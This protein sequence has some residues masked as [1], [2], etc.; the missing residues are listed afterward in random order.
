M[1]VKIVSRTYTNQFKPSSTTNFFLGNVGDWQK[2]TLLCSFAVEK[3]FSITESL[4]I[5]DPNILTLNDGT[6]WQENGFAVGMSCNLDFYYKDI[7]QTPAPTFFNRVSFTIQSING[8]TLEAS[9]L[10]NVP[11]GTAIS[12]W[13]YQYGQIAPIRG[14]DY[15]IE[16]VLVFADVFPQGIELEYSHMSNQQIP[17]GNLNS[18]VDGSRT[19]FRA[20]DTDLVAAG[21]KYA[22]L[23]SNDFDYNLSY[24]SGMSVIKATWLHVNI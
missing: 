6:T 9:S 24:Q 11:G 8:N 7:T 20:E 13:G 1:A 2:M 3:R 14:A 23:N 4:T 22:V 16:K 19:R 18:F 12:Q 5:Q 10:F 17:S 21:Q 15:E